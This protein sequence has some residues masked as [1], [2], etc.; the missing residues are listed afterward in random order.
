MDEKKSRVELVISVIALIV[1]VGALTFSLWY[2]L[3]PGN[4][5]LLKPSGYCII[6]EMNSFPSDHLVLPLEWENTGGRSVLIRHP[7]FVLRQL[8]S[9]G[10]ETGDEY[11]FSLAGE[12]PDI[13]YNSFAERY[14]IKQSFILDPHSLS[15]KVLVFHIK[16][17]WNESSELYKFRFSAGKNYRVY[18]GF[19][20]NLDKQPEVPLFEMTTFGSVDKLNRSGTDGNWWD[21]WPLEE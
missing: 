1:S 2:N 14:S 20:R 13:S 8:G 5:Q 6:R 10:K 7:Y 3:S 17:W 16:N 15:R 21:F 9:D 18:I 4:V 12:Y 19:Q 11:R